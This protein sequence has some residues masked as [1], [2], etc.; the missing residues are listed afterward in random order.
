M[1]MTLE[2]GEITKAGDY[3]TWTFKDAFRKYFNVVQYYG[4]VGA[5]GMGGMMKTAIM[6]CTK[7]KVIAHIT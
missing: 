6:I 7:W 1:R 4:T 2:N 5:T 3:D